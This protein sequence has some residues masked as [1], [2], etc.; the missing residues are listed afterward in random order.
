MK[1]KQSMPLLVVC[2]IALSLIWG[3]FS[4]QAIAK[5]KPIKLTYAFFAPAG[6][7]P[8]KQ[9][10]QWAMEMEKR[11]DG[12]SAKEHGPPVQGTEDLQALL[13]V[14]ARSGVLSQD[15]AQP[16]KAAP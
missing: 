13:D 4:A 11:T 7:F 12:W 14:G 8:G 9:M 10:A 15:K 2:L 1:V 6:T 3:G 16:P 5:D